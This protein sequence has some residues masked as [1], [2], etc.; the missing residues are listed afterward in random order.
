MSLTPSSAERR[1]PDRR[2][3]LAEGRLVTTMNP[4]LAGPEA[5]HCQ[6]RETIRPLFGKGRWGEAD[7]VR[8]RAPAA[9][10]YSFAYSLTACNCKP[11]PWHP[12]RVLSRIWFAG[13]AGACAVILS[14]SLTACGGGES[15]NGSATTTASTSAAAPEQSSTPV[16]VCAEAGR[17]WRALD[18]RANG[19]R[20]RAA[21]LGRGP[22][23]VF[24][25]QSG[26]DLCV[27]M[28]LARRMA[29]HG[30]SAAV[31]TYSFT[32]AAHERDIAREA[33]AVARAATASRRFVLIGASLGGRVVFVAA[34]AGPHGLGGIVSLSGERR[35]LDYADILPDVRRVTT[36]LLYV[37][38]REDGWTDGTRQPQ[39]L[40][41]AVG[42]REA[43]FILVPGLAHGVELLT[44]PDSGRVTRAIDQF[45]TRHLR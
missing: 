7:R 18:A 27:W 19:R 3:A 28:A 20:V 31:F 30:R 26:N 2:G 12:C 39:K 17:G 41:A 4:C 10:A 25:N 42:S 35:V 43:R 24:L 1:S 21:V 37:G 8:R 11:A 16:D 13:I 36:P 6:R 15:S 40:R 32:D 38:S 29:D 34:A 45:V 44:G 5:I 9:A 23:V 22:A 33:L 14:C